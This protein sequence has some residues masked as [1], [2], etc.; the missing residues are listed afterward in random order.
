M[1]VPQLAWKTIIRVSVLGDCHVIL[2]QT[3]RHVVKSM[4][5][6]TWTR[7]FDNF[8]TVFVRLSATGPTRERQIPSEDYA[9]L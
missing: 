5:F 9:V 1:F 6:N 8:Y 7:S 3:C 2:L 4:R